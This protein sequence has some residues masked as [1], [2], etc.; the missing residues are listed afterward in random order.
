MSIHPLLTQP[1]KKVSILIP[2][3]NETTSL[4]LTVD[5]IEKHCHYDVLEYIL[6]VCKK[7]TPESLLL[8][9]QYRTKSPDRYRIHQQTKP[10]LGNAIQEGIQRAKASHLIIM[11]S[12]LET[13][14]AQVAHFIAQAKH[15][16]SHV[17]TA[18]RWRHDSDFTGYGATKKMSNYLF[19]KA[20]QL[21]YWTTLSDLTFCYRLMPT[22]LAQHIRWQHEKHP[23]LLETCLK[24]LRL[25]VTF[26]EISASWKPRSEGVSQNSL[27]TM[28]S[29]IPWAFLWR[30]Q[31]KT[32]WIKH[33]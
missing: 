14:P 22:A 32:K 5:S 31:N 8:C 20:L 26:T 21:L 16:P 1:F 10:F 4:R 15:H 33:K 7:T 29:D 17:I 30:L 9:N 24:P 18:S 6:I 25:N 2:V 28:L 19:Q 27:R 12:D 13:N 3:I 23:F 11:A